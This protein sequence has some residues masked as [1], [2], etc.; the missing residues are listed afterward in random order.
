MLE[1]PG[2]RWAWLMLSAVAVIVVGA[3]FLQLRHGGRGGKFQEAHQEAVRRHMQA[4]LPGVVA[5]DFTLQDL[6]GT[7]VT[8]SQYRGQV[9]LLNLWALWCFPCI[10]EMPSMQGLYERM[11]GR[12]FALLAVEVGLSDPQE[13]LDFVSQ[14]HLTFP[15]LIDADG[16]MKERYPGRGIPET[17]LIGRDGK[18]AGRFIGPR[19]WTSESMLAHIDRLLD[20]HG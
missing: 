8:L 7:T 1:R 12:G 3:A 6:N 2:R 14:N 19:D 10:D 9:I 13:I 15:V 5:P 16:V 4:P 18:V 20:E 17:Y 11:Q